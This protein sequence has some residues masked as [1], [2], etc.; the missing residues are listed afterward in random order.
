MPEVHELILRLNDEKIRFE[1]KKELQTYLDLQIQHWKWLTKLPSAY[2]ESG[3]AIFETYFLSP[4]H[5]VEQDTINPA[6]RE[7]RLGNEKMPFILYDSDE[8]FLI[9]KTRNEYDD[10]TA[11]LT[12]VYLNRHTRSA[13]HRDGQISA[14]TQNDRLSFEKSVAIQIAISL[15]GFSSIGSD[16]RSSVMRETLERFV[17]H[18]DL[19]TDAINNY[20]T[21][22]INST[23][24]AKSDIDDIASSLTAAY[25]KRRKRYS[26][27]MIKVRNSARAAVSEA[28]NTL[29]SAK[30]AY[31]DQVDLDASVHYWSA[32]KRNHSIFK[33]IWFFAILLSMLIMF[34]SVLG[35]YGAGGAMGLS[36]MIHQQRTEESISSKPSSTLAD[37]Q[38][39]STP[40]SNLASTPTKVAP[41]TSESTASSLTPSSPIAVAGHTRSEL[42][43]AV[44]DLAGVALLITLLGILIKITL[45]QF[46]THSYLALEA[47][48]RITFTKTY[49][50]LLNEGKLKSEEDRKLVLESLFR[51][52]KSGAVEEIPFSS[53]VELIFK[54]IG[55]RKPG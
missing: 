31:H 43:L 15:K 54:T 17:S 44:A 53:P 14:L 7:F 22:I 37:S 52:T 33:V 27:Y 21:D 38:L 40:P 25:L 45:R 11:A 8:G 51:S 3:R 5:E 47:E 30:M 46:N 24:S 1:N 32:R 19:A 48:E 9:T 6:S 12:I 10:V 34:G 23:S 16:A 18:A 42:T 35:Y 4:I 36:N 26:A 28:V 55:D 2:R 29:A 39:S 20:V 41:I 50:A 13:I 49:L